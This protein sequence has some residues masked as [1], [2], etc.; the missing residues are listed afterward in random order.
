MTH[1]S[2]NETSNGRTIRRRRFAKLTFRDGYD[3]YSSTR[4]VEKLDAVPILP[5]ADA[6][7]FDNRADVAR[8][9]V[10]RREVNGQHDILIELKRHL[11]YSGYIVI[12]R[13]LS[14]PMSI[15]QILRN[16]TIRPFGPVRG[17]TISYRWP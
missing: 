14:V 4:H 3:G 1:L 9:E 10:M 2:R 11:N 17:A 8:A 7:M 12:N 5:A 13:G 6:M 15:C 16:T